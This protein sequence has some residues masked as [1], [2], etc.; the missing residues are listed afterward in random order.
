MSLSPNDMVSESGPRHYCK[1]GFFNTID[2]LPP[3]SQRFSIAECGPAA[4]TTAR[5]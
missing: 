4:T 2:P 1:A 3:F 5:V